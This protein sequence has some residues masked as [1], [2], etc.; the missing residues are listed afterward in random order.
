MISF[1]WWPFINIHSAAW[2]R[3]CPSM[4]VWDRSLNVDVRG[5]VASSEWRPSLRLTT[6][7]TWKLLFPVEISSG[8]LPGHAHLFSWTNSVYFIHFLLCFLTISLHA[9]HCLIHPRTKLVVFSR[10]LNSRSSVWFQAP[11][12]EG[13]CFLLRFSFSQWRGRPRGPT[14]C[15]A[16]DAREQI[17][18]SFSVQ[19][20]RRGYF[21]G[22]WPALR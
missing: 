14:R 9:V 4:H 12:R 6:V 21:T 5:V 18:C 19:S 17:D 22:S 2:A 15:L 10:F 1:S 7:D 11:W 8:S 13:Q 3:A 16:T 20:V